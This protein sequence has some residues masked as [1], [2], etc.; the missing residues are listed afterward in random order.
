M[1]A[2]QQPEKGKREDF[3]GQATATAWAPGDASP[4]PYAAA[5]HVA[6]DPKNQGN[7]ALV[8]SSV[9][10]RPVAFVHSI[11]KDGV[12]NLAPFY[13]FGVITHDPPLISI[14]IC[15][16]GGEPKDTAR[17]I[18]DTE[19]FT[20]SLFPIGWFKPRHTAQETSRLML[21]SR[22]SRD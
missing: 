1:S 16:K 2:T 15:T 5:G 11:S 18:M 6:I 17:N 19:E 8:I 21:T 4:S 7:Y 3:V 14:G 10:P 13:F 12:S 9:V 20:V 22:R